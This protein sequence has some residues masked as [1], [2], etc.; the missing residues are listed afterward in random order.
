MFANIFQDIHTH[1]DFHFQSLPFYYIPVRTSVYI[2]FKQI[3]RHSFPFRYWRVLWSLGGNR[4]GWKWRIKLPWS[5]FLLCTAC[6]CSIPCPSLD[7]PGRPIQYHGLIKMASASF[8]FYGVRSLHAVLFNSDLS[9]DL[10]ESQSYSLRR[11]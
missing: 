5:C 6:F 11:W 1:N 3:H 9:D 2:A 7:L 10:G 8:R 4:M